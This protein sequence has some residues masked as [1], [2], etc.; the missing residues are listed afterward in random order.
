M[1]DLVRSGLIIHTY[2]INFLMEIKRKKN[3]VFWG[4]LVY[5]VCVCVCILECACKCRMVSVSTG[6]HVP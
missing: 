1:S 2:T 4:G 3:F 6:V 5:L